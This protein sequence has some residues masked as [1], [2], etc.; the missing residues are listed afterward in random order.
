MSIKIIKAGIL[1]TIQDRGRTGYRH[2]GINPSGAM[3]RF[4]AQLANA[5]LGKELEEPVIEM[6]FPACAFLFQQTTIACLAGA[7]FSATIN[8]Q[9][10]SL[11]QPFL[12]TENS[13][14]KFTSP[15]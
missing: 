14:L 5:L 2:L 15:V 13:V 9:R 8:E 7:D 1:D 11:H 4:S 10:I 6:H 12:I 3:D